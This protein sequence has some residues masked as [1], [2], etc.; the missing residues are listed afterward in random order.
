MSEPGVERGLRHREVAEGDEDHPQDQCRIGG[1]GRHSPGEHAHEQHGEDGD[2]V[3]AV[4]LLQIPED[5]G[6]IGQERGQRHGQQGTDETA[7]TKRLALAVRSP[8]RVGIQADE[9]GR[10]VGTELKV[11]MIAPTTTAA[12]NPVRE[13]GRTSR[14]RTP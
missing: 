3:E 11:L 8:A 10:A 14:T 6:L 5:A 2:E 9:G 13:A 4:H 1:D 7:R 12:K